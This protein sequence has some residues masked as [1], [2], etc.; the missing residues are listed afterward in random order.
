MW[1]S[2]EN[3][4]Q[5][6]RD[7]HTIVADS[8]QPTAP[9]KNAALPPVFWALR[10]R[11]CREQGRR[12]QRSRGFLFVQLGAAL[13]FHLHLPQALPSSL[14]PQPQVLASLLPSVLPSPLAVTYPSTATRSQQLFPPQILLSAQPQEELCATRAPRA[15]V[16]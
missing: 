15:A 13:N 7:S 12:S 14:L 3:E 5:L 2:S 16:Q 1:P 9:G 8:Q 11:G 4:A 6:Y 10:L